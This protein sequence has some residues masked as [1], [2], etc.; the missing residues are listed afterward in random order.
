[1]VISSSFRMPALS[2]IESFSKTAP[3]LTNPLV[4][5]GLGLFLVFG[6][7][8]ALIKSGILPPV[9]QRAS[10]RIVRLLIHYGFIVAVLLILLG[11]SL[12]ALD[13]YLKIGAN[14]GGKKPDLLLRLVWKKEFAV[15]MDARDG[16]VKSPAYSIFVWDLDNPGS[17]VLHPQVGSQFPDMWIKAGMSAGPYAY[18][19]L[20]D[21]AKS[22]KSGDRLFG[23]MWG[24]CP[25]CAETRAYWI[26]AIHGDSGWFAE[27][28]KE[29]KY[30]SL[31]KTFKVLDTI[32]R[33]PEKFFSVADKR[34]LRVER[35]LPRDCRS[36]DCVASKP[37]EVLVADRWSSPPCLLGS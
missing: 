28:P 19:T 21:V 33:D 12:T 25:D 34:Q 35:S 7:H 10:D 37:Q 8:Q 6:V 22:I 15:M 1:M 29:Y 32:K 20:P 26:Y 31:T 11:F 17:N 36:P 14:V 9:S 4:L 3:Y 16:L 23:Y 2:D 5:V 27:I 30:P 13:R 24:T 18:T